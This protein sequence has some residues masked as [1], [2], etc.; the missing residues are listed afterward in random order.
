MAEELGVF[1][2]D[3]EGKIVATNEGARRLWG[4]GT[5][6][7]VGRAFTSLFRGERSSEHPEMDAIADWRTLLRRTRETRTALAMAAGEGGPEEVTLRVERAIGGAGSYIATVAP[8][9]R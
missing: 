8:A 6:V 9:G 1:V 7:L 2:I 5:E 4:V 3:A